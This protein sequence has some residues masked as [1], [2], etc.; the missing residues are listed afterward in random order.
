MA[1][2]V[3]GAPPMSSQ[4]LTLSSRISFSKSESLGKSFSYSS[5][6]SLSISTAPSTVPS[7]TQ[8]L[9][10][11]CVCVCVCVCLCAS[12]PNFLILP[13]QCTAAEAIGKPLEE[14]ASITPLAMWAS[15]ISSSLIRII[16][17]W[18][19]CVCVCV[20]FF[21][22]INY[23]KFLRWIA[24]SRGH[25]TRTKGEDHQRHRLLRLHQRKTVSRT[26]R[27]SRLT[28]MSLSSVLTANNRTWFSIPSYFYVISEP[29]KNAQ[30]CCSLVLLLLLLVWFITCFLFFQNGYGLIYEFSMVK[31]K[32]LIEQVFL[33]KI[34]KMFHLIRKGLLFV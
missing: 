28:L 29:P 19:L 18:N 9:I 22:L 2:L 16:L 25:G 1:S 8:L 13:V 21:F 32:I 11:V 27:L 4:S 34:A 10:S 30:C 20:F 6:S 33:S 3:L 17:L 7:G 14:N 24:I 15:S 12:C 26:I 31:K 5:P 23:F